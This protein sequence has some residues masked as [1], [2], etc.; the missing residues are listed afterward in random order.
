M[1]GGKGI[2]TELQRDMPSSSEGFTN[3]FTNDS[4]LHINLNIPF[5][6]N[7]ATS[8]LGTYPRERKQ[9]SQSHR[10]IAALNIMAQTANQPSVHHQENG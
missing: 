8:F 10:N 1:I 3:H 6:N 4:Q 2:V 7:P 9:D 5:L